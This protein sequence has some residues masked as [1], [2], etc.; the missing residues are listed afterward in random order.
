[1]TADVSRDAGPGGRASGTPAPGRK[2]WTAGRVTA[3][4]LGSILIL[5]SVGLLGGAGIL[6]WAD[7]EQWGGFLATGTA[8]YSTGGYALA[9][10]PVTVHGRWG[11]LGWFVGEVQIQVTAADPRVPV[12]VAIGPASDVSR[13]LAGVSCASM[14]AIGDHDV[15]QHP[16][17]AVPALPATAL[18]WAVQAQGTGTQTLHWTAR[19]GEWMAVVMNPDGSPGVTVRADAGITSPMLPAFAG[20]LLS[21]AIVAGLI[22]AALAVISSRLAAGAR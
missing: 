12:F 8:T 5:A 1:M 9:S 22:G 15:T 4:A 11:W 19:T 17:S 7:Q 2:G 10:D 16:G 14:A 20:Q 6:M 13:Y 21:M 3:L 18:N